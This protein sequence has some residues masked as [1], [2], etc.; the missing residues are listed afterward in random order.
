MYVHNQMTAKH[1]LELSPTHIR[2][3]KS[4]S[5]TLRKTASR[6]S[7]HYAN[8]GIF[9]LLAHR[10]QRSI[11][12]ISYSKNTKT[13]SW[14]AHGEY[15]QREHAQVKGEK[16][17]GF[18]ESNDAVDLRSTLRKWQQADDEH[19]FRLIISPENGHLLDLKQHAKDMMKI[20]QKDF[21]TKLEWLAI[22]HH[23]TDH[24]HLHVLIRGVD[25]RG[26]TLVID[27]DYLTHGFRHHSES[28]ATQ[29]LGLRLNRDIIQAR[30]RQ[31]EREYVTELDRSII[32][33]SK[34]C[35]IS[36][37]IPV[38]DNILSREQRLLE[39]RRLQ[40][41]E[42]IG[43]AEK[44]DSKAWRLSNNLEVV[45]HEKQ[46]AN[47]IIKSHARHDIQS[48]SHEVPAP[49]EIQE[50]KPL[51][52]KVVGMGLENELK[53]QRY[54]LL[55]GIDGKVH[56]LQAT[57]SIIKA[58]DNFEFKNDDVITIEKNS[59]VNEHRKK[60][61]YTKI[62]NHESLDK[63]QNTPDSRLNRDVIEF[64]KTYSIPPPQQHP[65][66]S[67]AHEYGGLMLK[68]FHELEKAAIF[69]KEKEIY[70]LADDWENK[71]SLLEKQ[72]QIS[73]EKNLENR[74]IQSTL[75]K[76]DRQR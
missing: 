16:G 25:D 57:N 51:T 69:I 20:V 76:L 22:D 74:I 30:E 50:H 40:F 48:L 4:Y 2:H 6:G 53:D 18:S 60:V 43:L 64:V 35:V 45:L 37:H 68:R 32:R 10:N 56:Y 23:N 19:V 14:A 17:L 29:I 44:I 42:K 15:L 11:V 9:H 24:P 52:G 73:N 70:Y 39:I 5:Y 46:L 28:L 38:S 49:T 59:F 58:R 72:R 8:H 67:F 13:R 21:K 34:D 62:Y 54:L 61:E 66:E 12:K 33:K 75:T 36:Y 55:E 65:K 31:I 3:N 26:K 7:S 63:L 71:L 27:K 1:A 41:L 47:D